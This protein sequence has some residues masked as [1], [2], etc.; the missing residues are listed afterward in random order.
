MSSADDSVYRQVPAFN[1]FADVF[2]PAVYRPL[3]ASW[4]IGMTDVVDSTG[5][6]AAGQYKRVNMAGA[7]AISAVMNA[8]GHRDFPFVFGG[9]GASFA[10]SA[11][12]RDGAADALARTANWVA[13]ELDLS[14]RA[15]MVPVAEVEANGR[16]VDVARFAASPGVSYAMFSGQ[17]IAW[18]EEEMKMGRY[19]VAPAAD[20]A[21]PDL[22]GLSCRWTPIGNRRGCI[23]SLLLAPAG[24]AQ[25]PEYLAI[26]RDVVSLL[27]GYDRG[28]HPVPDQGP[29]AGWPPPGVDLEARASR[30]D[31]SVF[32][33]KLQLWAQ[34]LLA[35]V[36]FASGWK[37]G[38][39]DPNEYRRETAMNTDYRKFDDVLRLTV[40][41]APEMVARIDALLAEARD[42]GIVR[43]GLCQQEAALMTCI[44]PSV[45]ERDH[46]H[47]LDGADGGYAR[48]AMAL[49]AG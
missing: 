16:E 24:P 5:A 12:D 14:L 28:G 25:D 2:N 13:A 29:E 22:T 36:L 18:A 40:D 10:V 34:S 41:C 1:D 20:G 46:M 33:R 32:A 7:A 17:G 11:E 6:I 26:A 44:V 43:Y 48:A 21:R 9:D 30:G 49:K 42:R 39:F 31:G 8:L 45:M 38:S 19:A 23:L 3:P 4:W 37:L 27:G 15:A 35:K 47:F